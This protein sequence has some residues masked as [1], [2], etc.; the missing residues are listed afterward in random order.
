MEIKKKNYIENV[1]FA[2]FKTLK[3]QVNISHKLNSKKYTIIICFKRFSL[4][5]F[6]FFLVLIQQKEK[7]YKCMWPLHSTSAL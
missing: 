1:I 5:H 7:V 6:N 2:T 3:V 4:I